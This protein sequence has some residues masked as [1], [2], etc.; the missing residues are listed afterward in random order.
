MF[1]RLEHGL[2]CEILGVGPARR[3]HH[4]ESMHPRQM[5][6]EERCTRDV[7]RSFHAGVRLHR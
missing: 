3:H 1:D 7:W 2:L 6:S 4:G 5:R